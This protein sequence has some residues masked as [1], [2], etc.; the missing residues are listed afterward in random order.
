MRIH[1]NKDFDS[2]MTTE[3]HIT[4]TIELDGVKLISFEELEQIKAEILK[5]VWRD[6]QGQIVTRDGF[7]HGIIT[8]TDIIDNH[9]SELKGENK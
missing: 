8:A 3:A 7:N 2:Y 6:A 9:I 1:Y 4:D 5:K